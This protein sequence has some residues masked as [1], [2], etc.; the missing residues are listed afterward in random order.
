[1]VSSVNYHANAIGIWWRLWEIDL[2]FAPGLH[3]KWTRFCV[4]ECFGTLLSVGK[5]AA[6]V[7]TP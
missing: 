7:V 5:A 4:G 2:R 6:D 1:M 3:P